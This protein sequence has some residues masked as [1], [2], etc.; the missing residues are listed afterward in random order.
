MADLA[1]R[2]LKRLFK[3]FSKS[4]LDVEGFLTDHQVVQLASA[5]VDPK[6]GFTHFFT[7][8]FVSDNNDL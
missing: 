2:D 5:A 3:I 6:S 7:M 4:I 1:L 8:I